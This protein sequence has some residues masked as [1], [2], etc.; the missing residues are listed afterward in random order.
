MFLESRYL[1]GMRP[2]AGTDHEVVVAQEPAVGEVHDLPARLHG[3]HPAVMEG[4]PPAAQPGP[5]GH[6]QPPLP[7]L[8]ERQ[9]DHAR[10]EHEAV[11]VGD[12]REVNAILERTAQQE[13]RFQAGE[14][15]AYQ[16]DAGSSTHRDHPSAQTPPCADPLSRTPRRGSS[17]RLAARPPNLELAQR[18]RFAA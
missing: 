6:P 7:G 5:D 17:D 14:S 10:L 4:D 9:S 16:D 3:G 11:D 8:A 12:D 1:L 2:S 13:R 18:S 15:A